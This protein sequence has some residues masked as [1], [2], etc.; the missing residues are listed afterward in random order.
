MLS[1]PRD[2]TCQDLCMSEYDSFEDRLRAMADQISQ[3]VRACLRLTWGSSPTGTGS[4][5]SVRVALLTP[6]ASG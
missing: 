4:T 5:R 6:L 3:S 2:V 1:K